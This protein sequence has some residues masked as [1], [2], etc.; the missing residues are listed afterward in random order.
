MASW[1]GY[2]NDHGD[3]EP[4]AGAIAASPT[5]SSWPTPSD[6]RQPV[7]ARE[8]ISP[9]Q[10][11][12]CEKGDAGR[13]RRHPRHASRRLAHDFAGVAI[14]SNICAADGISLGGNKLYENFRRLVGETSG[15]RCPANRAAHRTRAAPRRSRRRPR[16]AALP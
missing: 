10:K 15:F 14:S 9:T 8:V 1:P 3:S 11:L 7:S 5:P 6:F 12:Y 2:P 4:E 13:Q 16:A